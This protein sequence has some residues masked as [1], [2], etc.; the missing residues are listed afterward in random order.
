MLRLLLR[1]YNS[2]VFFL[3]WKKKYIFKMGCFDIFLFVRVVIVEVE[4]YGLRDRRFSV[5][6]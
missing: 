4:V 1:F 5:E 3:L 6:E 2:L